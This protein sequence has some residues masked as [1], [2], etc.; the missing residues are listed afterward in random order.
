MQNGYLNSLVY[1]AVSISMLFFGYLSDLI[2]K[3]K[4]LSK[5]FS[6]KL[7]ESISQFGTA[8]CLILVPFVGCN[9]VMLII[10]LILSMFL[11]GA[12]AGG[13]GPIVMDIAPDYSGSLYGFTNSVSSIPGFVAPV[14]I[15]LLLEYDV[16]VKYN[17]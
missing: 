12:L 8:V 10:L 9:Y 15:G 14:V 16:S 1:I 13:D 17:H 2:E 7:F 3:R 5:N 4:T 11:Y 6:R